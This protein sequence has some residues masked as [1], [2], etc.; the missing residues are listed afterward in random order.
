MVMKVLLK[1]FFPDVFNRIEFG[2]VWRRFQKEDVFWR[3]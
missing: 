3:Y 2:S 1:Q